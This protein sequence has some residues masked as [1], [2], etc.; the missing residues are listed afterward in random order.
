MEIDT[1]KSQTI[2]VKISA[3]EAIQV[4]RS[5]LTQMLD[6]PSK[7]LILASEGTDN[8]FLELK[9]DE[10]EIDVLSRAKIIVLERCVDPIANATKK[11][12]KKAEPIIPKPVKA[13]MDQF[14]GLS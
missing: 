12:K 4:V 9:V 11:K 10:K 8:R 2:T 13:I 5:V 14:D 7:S 6:K 3:E 1:S